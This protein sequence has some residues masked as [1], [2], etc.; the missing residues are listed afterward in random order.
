VS[1]HHNLLRFALKCL[2]PREAAVVF[3]GELARLARHPRVVGPALLQVAR[4]LPEIV[5]LRRSL[6]PSRDA[7]ERLLAQA[8][9]LG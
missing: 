8:H 7:L 3:A 4:E 6:T 5:R 1:A 2:P 9:H